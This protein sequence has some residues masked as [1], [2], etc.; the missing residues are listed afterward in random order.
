MHDIRKVNC[1][2]LFRR[3]ITKSIVVCQFVGMNLL[4]GPELVAGAKFFE[5]FLVLLRGFG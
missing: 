3:P 5:V 1:S 4:M 2:S